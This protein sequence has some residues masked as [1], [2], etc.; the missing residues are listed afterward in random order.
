MVRLAMA[1]ALPWHSSTAHA[2]DPSTTHMTIT[3]R[4][5]LESGVHQ[6]WMSIS[7]G[8][9]GWFTA[10][11][12]DPSLLSDDERRA[13]EVAARATPASSGSRPRGGPGAC[14]GAKAPPETRMHCV[15]GDLWEAT[16]LGWLQFGV[17]AE[18]VPR[19]RLTHHFA[20]R[21]DGTAGTW[22]DERMPRAL[23][24]GRMA[25]RNGSP[26][27]G[28]VTRTAFSGTSKSAF[29]WVSGGK[30][31]LSPSALV[32]HLERAAISE[33]QAVRDHHFALALICAGAL[34]HV[35]QDLTTPA[36]ARSDLAA[37]FA[38]LSPARGDRGLPLQEFARV[39]FGRA[40]KSPANNLLALRQPQALGATE[41]TLAP[42]LLTHFEG[43]G[44]WPGVSQFTARRFLSEA[45]VPPPRTVQ[46]QETDDRDAQAAALAK[47]ALRDT[48]LTT[49]EVD[50]ATLRPWPATS[51]YLLSR[52]GRPLAAF[53]H[54]NGKLSFHL[55]E[56]VYRDQILQLLPLATRVSRSILETVWLVPPQVQYVVRPSVLEVN[57]S[58]Q[59][60]PLEILLLSE[61]E[62]G[63][64]KPL[65]RST[66][67]VGIHRVNVPPSKDPVV[68]VLVGGLRGPLPHEIRLTEGVP[69][70]TSPGG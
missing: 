9:L 30:D 38:P 29:A 14:P 8:R 3:T 53:N 62:D 23:V 4:A 18:V 63:R 31:W 43:H 40:F 12:I 58:D 44:D 65:A 2:W 25:R 17:V 32:R 51:G 21:D 59:R 37:F 48:G 64:R 1:A 50:G 22:R 70:P 67:S 34:L 54:E 60:Q 11:R 52:G 69:A 27:A 66:L 39:H 56:V 5:A 13:M 10:L 35:A 46:P 55:D 28:T 33:T 6:R 61:S 49:H 41:G 26:R 47:D 45:T 16:A 15:E 24:R 36:H 57:L 19:E 20:D 68:A 42:T 7:K